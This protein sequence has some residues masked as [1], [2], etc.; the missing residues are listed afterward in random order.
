MFLGGQQEIKRWAWVWSRIVQNCGVLPFLSYELLAT[1]PGA[2]SAR[3]RPAKYGWG[4]NRLV[5]MMIAFITF[6]SLVPLFEGLWSW[7]P[8]EFKLSG[9]RRNRNDD[10]DP[11]IDSFS[12]WPTESRLH[13]RYKKTFFQTTMTHV[14]NFFASFPRG[15]TGTRWREHRV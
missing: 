14:I 11:G 10:R 7:N 15:K 3:K 6:N 5:M 13:V 1:P 4:E 9:F 8:W 12:L 2:C